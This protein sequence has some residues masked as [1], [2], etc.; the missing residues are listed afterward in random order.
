MKNIKPSHC[1]CFI[2]Q[3]LSDLLNKNL[4]FTHFKDES[5]YVT[6]L[7]LKINFYNF[8][9]YLNNCEMLNLST[10]DLLYEVAKRIGGVRPFSLPDLNLKNQSKFRDNE[11]N[12]LLRKN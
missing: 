10:D 6:E 8:K 5:L 4:I 9:F 1:S 2:S 3:K 12:S 11:I 7:N